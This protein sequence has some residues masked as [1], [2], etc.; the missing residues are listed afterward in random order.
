MDD[1]ARLRAIVD[2]ALRQYPRDSTF[3]ARA[4]LT[5]QLAELVADARRNRA[6]AVHVELAPLGGLPQ[7]GSCVLS[8][9]VAPVDDAVVAAR[10]LAELQ[11]ARRPEAHVA[12][13][14]VADQPAVR[15]QAR[16]REDRADLT[17]GHLVDVF[18]TLP[19][20][21]GFVLLAFAFRD[22]PV[23]TAMVGLVD[24]IVDTISFS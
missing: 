11:L 3:A 19:D 17:P 9:I 21:S 4:A 7:G 24:A 16:G 12:L 5:E 22:T 20:G 6:L 10:Q 23:A 13:A 14:T 15:V 18:V 1:T 8:H 2:D